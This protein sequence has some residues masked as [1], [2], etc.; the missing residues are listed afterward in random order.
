MNER[1]LH[2]TVGSHF[3]NVELVQA[4]IDEAIAEQGA[5]EDTRHWIS[6]AVR[7]AVA[8]AIKHGN[9]QNPDKRVEVSVLVTDDFVDIRISDEGE[10]FDPS[11]L[12]D[13][14]APENRLRTNGRGIFYMR[15]F[16]DEVSYA[17]ASS[18]GTSVVMRKRIAPGSEDSLETQG[19]YR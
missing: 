5:D 4:A 3:D 2:L 1:Q 18:G 9:Q 7:E 16:M 12:R 8:N 15:R 19:D 11:E 17:T 13:P 14:L 6:L 10:G